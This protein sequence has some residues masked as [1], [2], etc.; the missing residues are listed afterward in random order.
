MIEIDRPAKFTSINRGKCRITEKFSIISITGNI[1]SGSTFP[2]LKSPVSHQVL[3]GSHL[4]TVV[5]LGSLFFGNSRRIIGIQPENHIGNGILGETG[6]LTIAHRTGTDVDKIALQFHIEYD[7]IGGNVT[8]GSTHDRHEGCNGAKVLGLIGPN[9]RLSSCI[10]SKIAV[11]KLRTGHQIEQIYCEIALNIT[12]REDIVPR[13]RIG[14]TIGGSIVHMCR[15]GRTTIISKHTV[16]SRFGGTNSGSIPRG[17]HRWGCLN[18][19]LENQGIIGGIVQATK[20]RTV[21]ILK[22]QIDRYN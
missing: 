3:I 6:G 21:G 8:N 12:G 5:D 7:T 1:I 19:E 13:S 17:N 4:I 11:V 18:C 14:S 10:E 2:F 22:E 9:T 16:E 20:Q 15:G